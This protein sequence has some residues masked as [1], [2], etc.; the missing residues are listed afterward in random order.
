MSRRNNSRSCRRRPSSLATSMSVMAS[1]KIADRGV[2][3]RRLATTRRF[4]R[5]CLSASFFAQSLEQD[6]GFA[7]RL[8]LIGEGLDRRIDADQTRGQGRQ[9]GRRFFS[10][11]ISR[12][13]LLQELEYGFLKDVVRE[14]DRRGRSV[15]TP[16]SHEDA[17]L[18]PRTSLHAAGLHRD[19]E[20]VARACLGQEPA[21][22]GRD[23]L[24]DPP[25]LVL[26]LPAPPGPCPSHPGR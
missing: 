11:H 6:R 20:A 10:Q 7:V 16:P 26:P 5:S 13:D 4:A 14:R 15:Q 21:E 8:H 24:A 18:L 19:V 3:S 23:P 12:I 2:F 9:L 22:Q 25:W 1:E 17:P